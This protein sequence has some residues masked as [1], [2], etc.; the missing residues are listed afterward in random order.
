MSK[1]CPNCGKR[2]KETGAI[3]LKYFS[4]IPFIRKEQHL[5]RKIYACK[6]CGKD[7]YG[8]WKER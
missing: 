8:K 6:G 1:K 7:Y 3:E 4:A 5:A 2:N